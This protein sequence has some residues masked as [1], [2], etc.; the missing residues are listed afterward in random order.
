MSRGLT[1]ILCK[2]LV[3]VSALNIDTAILIYPPFSAIFG[4]CL[5]LRRMSPTNPEVSSLG[6]VFFLAEVPEA[7]AVA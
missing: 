5:N 4:E 3:Y 2:Q 1:D 7:P 6:V